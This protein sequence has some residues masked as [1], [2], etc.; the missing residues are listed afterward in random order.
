MSAPF[1]NLQDPV[2][3]QS[4]GGEDSWTKV[5]YPAGAVIL[6]EG[7]TS[8]DFY[9]IFSGLVQVTKSLKD[10][11]STQKSL[12]TLGEGNFFGEGAL[13][14]DEGRGATVTALKDVVLLKLSHAHFEALVLRD[15]QA[16]V[17][18]ILGIVKVLNE[19]LKEGNERLVVLERVAQLHYEK[20]GNLAEVIPLILS[21]L[22]KVVHHPTLALFDSE[23][24]LHFATP[25]V[26]G[27]V[28]SEWTEFM[29]RVLEAHKKGSSSQSFLEAGSLY[30]P[31]ASPGALVGV[32]AA[33]VCETCQWEDGRLLLILA[34]ELTHF[35]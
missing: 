22:Q 13:L 35:L 3:F 4:F 33:Q 32:L 16:A 8:Q 34:Q 20:R 31:L 27:N 17:G 10:G 11:G 14:S 30:I 1:L 19:R 12:A 23:G 18:I 6:Q 29:P 21:E 15:P 26:E 9:F 5:T 25:E 2:V 24:R 7:E 28:L